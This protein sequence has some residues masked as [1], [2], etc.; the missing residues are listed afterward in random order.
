M[1]LHKSYFSKNNTLM[2]HTYTN[3]SMSPYI[4][5]FFG[6]LENVIMPNG[7]T[8][9]IFDLNLNPLIEKIENKEITYTCSDDLK[10]TLRM[11]NTSFFDTELLNETWSNGRRRATSFDLFIYRLPLTEGHE[12]EIQ[13][14]DEGV[15]YDYYLGKSNVGSS[16]KNKIESDKSFSDRPSN[17]FQRQTVENW[18]VEGIYD[19]D[20]NNPIEGLNYSGLTIIDTQH[21]EKGNEDIEF[22]MTD[23]INSILK[24]E[25]ERPSGWG[26]SFVP[27]VENITGMTENYSVGFFSRHTQTFYEP[28]LDTEYFN[29]VDDDRMR[30]YEKKSNKLYLYS[31]VFGNSSSL[32]Q[33]PTVDIYDMN[34]DIIEGFTDIESCEISKGV[35]EINISGLTSDNLPCMMYDVW[36]GISIDGIEIDN[37]E[38]D[39]VVNS[40]KDYLKINNKSESYDA[41]FTVSGIKNDEKIINTDVKKVEVFIKRAYTS[42]EILHKVDVQYRIYVK[43]GTTEVEVQEWSKL[44]RNSDGYYFFLDT[45]DKIP[46]EYFIDFKLNTDLSVNTYK[47][48]IKFQIVNRK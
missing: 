22:D 31:N 34:G 33:P 9:F 46:N 5:L 6:N 20:N 38:N 8:R 43:E 29:L 1:P 19:N 10:H 27:K 25:I 37:V 39:F 47:K 48:Q 17:W 13:S 4:E 7:F 23:E 40:F 41:S 36:K 42:K 12:G 24:G 30:F 3:T 16:V 15:G 11:K 35:Y 28:F 26:I 32:D 45:R 18:S 44:N 21:F 2:S 14:W